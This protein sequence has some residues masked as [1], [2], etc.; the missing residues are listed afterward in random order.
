MKLR[1][2][3]VARPNIQQQIAC[4]D[5]ISITRSSPRRESSIPSPMSFTKAFV[6]FLSFA[7]SAYAL[8]TPHVPH[9]PHGLHRALAARFPSPIPADPLASADPTAPVRKRQNKRCRP[10][11]S[12]AI[13][14]SAGQST[15]VLVPSAVTTHGASAST[16]SH[17]APPTTIPEIFTSTSK[18]VE[19]PVTTKGP[20]PSSTKEAE[21]PVTTKKPSST[22]EAEPPVTTKKPSPS[23]TKEAEPPVTT[24]KPSSPPSS[25]LPSFM[26]GTQNGEGTFYSSMFLSSL[27]RY[28]RSLVP[29]A[30]LGACGVT[31]KDTDH[32]AAV[33]HLLFDAFP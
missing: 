19:P 23:S 13:S 24:K 1:G 14:S 30:G 16:S 9:G 5:S 4:A 27:F 28:S 6:L 26:V 29:T 32:I 11:S 2:R 3:H 12:A 15:K 10:R 7:L 8:A 22:K 18:E 33:S 31:N 21:P 17:E 25:N 20:L